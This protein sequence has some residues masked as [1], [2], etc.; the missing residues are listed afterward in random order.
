[1]LQPEGFADPVRPNHDCLQTEEEHLWT[2][3]E[4]AHCWNT[5]LD[6]HLKSVGNCK[7]NADGSI[8]VKSVKEANARISFTKLGVYVDGIIPVSTTLQR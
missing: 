5:T 7:S 1:M 6:E 8:Y 3:K 2:Y 4:S